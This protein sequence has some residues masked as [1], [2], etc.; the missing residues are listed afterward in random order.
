MREQD[1][2]K[3]L[4]LLTLI[5]PTKSTLATMQKNIHRRVGI[6]NQSLGDSVRI[7]SSGIASFFAAQRVAAYAISAAV[8]VV[9]LI[10]A[11]TLVFPSQTHSVLLFA[12]IAATPNQFNK[13]QI[14]L[15]DTT[16]RFGSGISDTTGFSQSLAFTNT[17]LDRL[18]LKGDPGKYSALQCHQIYAAYRAFLEK[19][20]SEV[21][22]NA[23]LTSQ[24]HSYE[25]LAEKKLHM[26]SSL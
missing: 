13:A 11:T 3:N 10:G 19:K 12:R 2:I 5:A 8:V 7:F 26:Y 20:E 23:I 16:A 21:K 22:N 24:V 18:H 9:L 6:T 17:Q 25:E 1:C 14:A 4:R 15:T